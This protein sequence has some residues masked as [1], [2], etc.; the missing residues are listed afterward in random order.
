MIRS[1]PH[2][3]IATLFRTCAL[4]ISCEN[5]LYVGVMSALL[6]PDFSF[7]RLGNPFGEGCKCV[8]LLRLFLAQYLSILV[9]AL[10]I[11]LFSYLRFVA[12]IYFCTLSDYTKL[13]LSRRDDTPKLARPVG[14]P[15]HRDLLMFWRF[16]ALTWLIKWQH[17]S[18]QFQIM[19]NKERASSFVLFL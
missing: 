7:R 18:I 19:C 14:S 13:F 16:S 1:I 10:L 8:C 4:T 5:R 6:P 17:T 12:V 11:L 15:V 3:I 9:L 2:L